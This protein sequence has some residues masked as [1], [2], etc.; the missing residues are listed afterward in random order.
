MKILRIAFE[1]IRIF[2]EGFVIDFTAQDR[3]VN[4]DYVSTIYS[5]LYAQ[6]IISIVG[7][8]ASGKSTALKLI[9]MAMDI[10]LENK[11]LDNIGFLEGILENE[12]KMSVDFFNNDFFYRLESTIG[13]SRSENLIE[14]EK[15]KFFFLVETIYRKQ[16][17]EVK[18]KNMI[19]NFDEGHI[20]MRRSDFAGIEYSTLKDQDSIIAAITKKNSVH[21]IDMLTE[22][23]FNIY[24]VTGKAQMEYINLFDD[25]IESIEMKNNKLQISFKSTEDIAQC[26]LETISG[27]NY[28]SSGTIKGGNLLFLASQILQN[29]GYLI[30]DEIENHMHKKLVQTIIGFF[31]D[32]E[33]NKQGATLI[34]STHYS[35]ILDSI[36]RKDN[37]YVLTRNKNYVSKILKFSEEI[38]RNDIKK[39]EIFLSNYIKGTAPSYENI[40][41]VKEFLGKTVS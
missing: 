6:N 29:G 23:N 30:V 3:V 41:K 38:K 18:N 20:Q 36:E 21:H 4:T 34:F 14:I 7:A 16:K 31:A 15:K 10:V 28:L 8:N 17:S 25:S 12:T 22:T 27:D 1:N 24:S 33:T 2:S 11:S 37:I 40:M 26:E 13:I 32:K 19:F 9:K 5:R 39:S 35:E